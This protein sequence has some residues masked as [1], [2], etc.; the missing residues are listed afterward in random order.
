MTGIVA[1][2][3]HGWR[4]Q[5]GEALSEVAPPHC[6][7]STPS[8]PG[9]IARDPAGFSPPPNTCISTE[10]GLPAPR[11]GDAG[12]EPWRPFKTLRLIAAE[13]ERNP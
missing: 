3:R 4:T 7:S 13:E 1:A 8:G 10:V 9:A 5:K 12:E 6:S 11:E 2:D